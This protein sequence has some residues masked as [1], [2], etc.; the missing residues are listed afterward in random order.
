[1]PNVAKV[2]IWCAF[3]EVLLGEAAFD[4]PVK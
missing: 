4:K 2:Q 3:A 1:V